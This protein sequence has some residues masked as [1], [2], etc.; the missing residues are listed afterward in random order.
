MSHRHV[1]TAFH[2]RILTFI[3]MRVNE[4][5]R[6]CRTSDSLPVKEDFGLLKVVVECL[7]RRVQ[8]IRANSRGPRS[9]VTIFSYR[10]S[11]KIEC[12]FTHLLNFPSTTFFCAHTISFRLFLLPL[13]AHLQLHQFSVYLHQLRKSHFPCSQDRAPPQELWRQLRSSLE[14]HLFIPSADTSSLLLNSEYYP[15]APSPHTS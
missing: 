5:S 11:A 10:Q 8:A 13:C 2:F 9:H 14:V 15:V 4:R 6:G 1:A 7:L 12:N 3:V